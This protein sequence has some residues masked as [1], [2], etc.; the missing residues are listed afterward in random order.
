MPLG[1]AEVSEVNNEGTLEL[2]PAGLA[3]LEYNGIYF[4][5]RSWIASTFMFTGSYFTKLPAS[6]GMGLGV[7]FDYIGFNK[8]DR[9]L[10]D[11][12]GNYIGDLSL[13]TIFLNTGYGLVLLPALTVG[14]GLHLFNEKLG[15][16]GANHTGIILTAGLRY[17]FNFGENRLSLGALMKNAFSKGYSGVYIAG[18]SFNVKDTYKFMLSLEPSTALTFTLNTGLAAKIKLKWKDF[19]LDPAISWRQGFRNADGGS[20]NLGTGL[21]ISRIK[22]GVSF[23]YAHNIREFIFGSGL[24]IILRKNN[25]ERSLHLRNE[26]SHHLTVK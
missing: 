10:N 26:P 19:V 4:S 21:L 13:G 1:N 14:F 22:L 16:R 2:N 17:S 6:K 5:G 18:A 8:N 3:E 11:E 12:F 7:G 25:E 23:S 15:E 9:E 24:T 20:I